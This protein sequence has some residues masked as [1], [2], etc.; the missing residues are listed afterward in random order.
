MGLKLNKAKW[1]KDL[2]VCSGIRGHSP[3]A[4]MVDLIVFRSWF[5]SVRGKAR[6]VQGNFGGFELVKDEKLEWAHDLRHAC[7]Y[8]I[9]PLH[10]TYSLSILA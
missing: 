5:I 4:R 3:L 8:D 9:F 6:I 7:P 1:F 10:D 2:A